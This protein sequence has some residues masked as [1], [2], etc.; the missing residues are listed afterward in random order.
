M[1]RV[2]LGQCLESTRANVLSA[3]CCTA[4]QYI[5]GHKRRLYDQPVPCFRSLS[6]E[7][8]PSKG[9]RAR[10][11]GL[12]LLLASRGPGAPRRQL[13]CLPL[14]RSHSPTRSNDGLHS[15][16]PSEYVIRICVNWMSE[17]GQFPIQTS[18]RISL[19]YGG[20][21]VRTSLHSIFLVEST[22]FL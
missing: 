4:L 8:S 6:S 16:M 12:R 10:T 18:P 11:H 15:A 13:G 3:D 14:R 9:R 20:F 19:Y 22:F 21:Q 7:G 5:G 17:R 1:P 2:D